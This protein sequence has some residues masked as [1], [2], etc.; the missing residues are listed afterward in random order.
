[1]NRQRRK[2]DLLMDGCDVD[3]K[4]VYNWMKNKTQPSIFHL[5]IIADLLGVD[6]EELIEL[7]E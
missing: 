4:T 5:K 6:M 7:D 3:R 2:Q 1:M